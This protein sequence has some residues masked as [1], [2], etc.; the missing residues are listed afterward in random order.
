VTEAEARWLRSVIEDF[1]SGRLSWSPDDVPADD[2]PEPAVG[3]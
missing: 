3:S 2:A 1:R